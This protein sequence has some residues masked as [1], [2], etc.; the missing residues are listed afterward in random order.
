[1]QAKA[2]MIRARLDAELERRRALRRKRDMLNE[3]EGPYFTRRDML[4]IRKKRS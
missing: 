1:M 4:R 3:L 2:K